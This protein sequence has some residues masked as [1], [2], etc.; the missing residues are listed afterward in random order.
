MRLANLYSDATLKGPVPA[1]GTPWGKDGAQKVAP[2]DCQA[3]LCCP[4]PETDSYLNNESVSFKHSH[5][6]L[7]C[8]DEL[9]VKF[10]DDAQP[11]VVLTCGTQMVS[12]R[13][14]KACRLQQLM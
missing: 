2:V 7:M 13:V 3:W 5:I 4:A 11:Q 6:T 9:W 14:G 1:V 12:C 10:L 8:R